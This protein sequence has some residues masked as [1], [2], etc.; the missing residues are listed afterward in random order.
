MIK[1]SSEKILKSLEE[2]QEDTIPEKS[3]L[4]L[5]KLDQIADIIWKPSERLEDELEILEDD[6]EIRK[7]FSDYLP[8]D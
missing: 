3:K 7:V 5:D 2:T 4:I 1:I 6:L 8:H